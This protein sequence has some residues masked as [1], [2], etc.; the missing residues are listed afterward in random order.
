RMVEIDVRLTGD[1]TLVLMHDDM[2]DRTTN[3]TGRVGGM[4][5]G[6]LARLDA[7]WFSRNRLPQ[8]VGEPI[9]AFESIA[10]WCLANAMAINIEIKRCPGR[11]EE[12]GSSV[13]LDVLR[14]WRGIDPP[15][16]ISS[17]MESALA[18]AR[19][20]APQLPRA[21]LQERLTPDWP[22]RLARLECVAL[23]ADYR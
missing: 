22:E 9:P 18:A 7:G 19:E 16:L 11:E 1:G 4:T 10:R 2:V 5:W 12:T 14:L 15:P 6:E 23:D 8:F 3:G 17:F 20:V 21:L 13:A